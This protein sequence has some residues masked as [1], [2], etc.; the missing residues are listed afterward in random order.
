M[1]TAP[2]PLDWTLQSYIDRSVIWHPQVY[3]GF[4]EAPGFASQLRPQSLHWHT[5]PF[6][7]AQLDKISQQGGIYVLMRR[8][9]CLDSLHQEIILYLGEATSLRARLRKHLDSAREPLKDSQLLSDFGRHPDR[10]KLLFELFQPL[11]IR[12]CTLDASQEERRELEKQLIGL[13]DPP[14][15]LKHRPVPRGQPLL[16]R[17]GRI[18]ARAGSPQPAFS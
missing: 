1:L 5:L 14:F 10:L 6:E 3:N 4:R 18:P 16:G 7:E 17:P 15:N 11:V 13:L 8:Y 9:E 2:R 12:Y